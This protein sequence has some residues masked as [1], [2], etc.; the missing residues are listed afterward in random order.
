MLLLLEGQTGEAWE[1]SKDALVFKM[2]GSICQK[3]ILISFSKIVTVGVRLQ[4]AERFGATPPFVGARCQEDHES[5]RR[6]APGILDLG[7]Q[8]DTSGAAWR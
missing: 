5:A 4:G 2:L 6:G 8:I 1:P 7:D 3:S